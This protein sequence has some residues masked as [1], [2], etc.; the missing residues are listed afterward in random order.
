MLVYVLNSAGAA[1]M[2]CSS[3]KARRLLSEGKAKVVSRSPFT[4]KLLYGSSGYK[5]PV[6]LSVDSG[7]KVI[8]V[9]AV[10]NEQ[11]LYA[12]EVKTRTDVH[13][14]LSQR[15]SYRKTRRSRKLRYPQS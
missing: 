11:T 1:L 10:G 2:P 12:S 7:S 15:S 4:I 13:E 5:Q 9:A 8:G 14:K 3:G 6:T